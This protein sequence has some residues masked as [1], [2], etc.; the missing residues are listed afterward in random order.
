MLKLFQQASG[1]EIRI[2]DGEL[3]YG[4]AYRQL[5]KMYR[6]YQPFT[7]FTPIDIWTTY[8]NFVCC[9]YLYISLAGGVKLVFVNLDTAD[10]NRIFFV[11]L[12][13]I[14]DKVWNSK[15]ISI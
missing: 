2:T 4:S 10:P 8:W 3:Q 15:Y 5:Y 1:L 9:L 12:D 14:D 6:K 13:V 7:S 11:I